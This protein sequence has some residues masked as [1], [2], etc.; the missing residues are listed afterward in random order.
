MEKRTATTMY[1][2]FQNSKHVTLSKLLSPRFISKGL[3][4]IL[5]RTFFSFKVVS[6]KK[7]PLVHKI[8]TTLFMKNE[9]QNT[10]SFWENATV[11]PKTQ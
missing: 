2:S 4:D 6:F 8:N 11:P 5:L 9:G 7:F 3:P 1:I 10:K